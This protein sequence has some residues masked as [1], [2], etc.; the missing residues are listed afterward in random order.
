M[1]DNNRCCFLV[2]YQM[3][4]LQANSVYSLYNKTFFSSQRFHHVDHIIKFYN[5]HFRV[6]TQTNLSPTS[7]TNYLILE[8]VKTFY[9]KPWTIEIVIILSCEVNCAKITVCRYLWFFAAKIL[10][11]KQTFERTSRDR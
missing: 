6:R 2:L 4:Y 5:P 11:T 9:Y 8:M 1:Q 3:V 7:S 10:S